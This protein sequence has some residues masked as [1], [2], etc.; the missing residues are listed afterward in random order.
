MSKPPH[1]KATPAVTET[2]PSLPGL[3]PVSDKSLI[4][5]FDGGDMSS[6][7]GLLALRE[8]EARLG[9]AGRL[10][11]CLRDLRAPER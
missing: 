7:G 9:V 4:A 8:I 10:A 6:D 2:T 5:R 3:S 11:A 1:S